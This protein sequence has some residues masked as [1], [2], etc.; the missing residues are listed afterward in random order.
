VFIK[1]PETVV[2][3]LIILILAT[4]A[5]A[6]G[7]SDGAAPVS[8]TQAPAADTASNLQPAPTIVVQ[9]T[10]T[11]VPE[12]TPTVESTASA[13]D[14]PITSLT[15]TDY[16]LSKYDPGSTEYALLTRVKNSA[17]NGAGKHISVAIMTAHQEFCPPDQ[18]ITVTDEIAEQADSERQKLF[19]RGGHTLEGFTAD[20]YGVVITIPGEAL[21]LYTTFEFGNRKHALADVWVEID[22]T[23]YVKSCGNPSGISTG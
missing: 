3:Q 8:P 11:S 14:D 20:E 7:T 12:P 4:L 22:G 21:V 18:R 5:I 16:S 1:H 15:Q 10:A 19:H 2:L 13:P 9:A 23:W 6:C 17:Q